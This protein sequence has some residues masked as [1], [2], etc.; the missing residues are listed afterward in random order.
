MSLDLVQSHALKAIHD[1]RTFTKK[2]GDSFTFFVDDTP[3]GATDSA[4]LLALIDSGHAEV[5]DIGPGVDLL[6]TDAGMAAL[7]ERYGSQISDDD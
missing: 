1:G 4:P 3:L 5:F 7:R 2:T 6:V